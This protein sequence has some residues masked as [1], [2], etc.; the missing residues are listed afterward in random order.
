[1][2]PLMLWQPVTHAAAAGLGIPAQARKARLIVV[3][4]SV[5]G[6]ADG[7]LGVQVRGEQERTA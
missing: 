1:M 6:Q 5:A 2:Q 3:L 7:F 4:T